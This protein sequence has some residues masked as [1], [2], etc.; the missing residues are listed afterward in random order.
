MVWLPS[1]IDAWCFYLVLLNFRLLELGSAKPLV[2]S[3]FSFLFLVWWIRAAI[4][5]PLF[6][7]LS[8]NNVSRSPPFRLFVWLVA[9]AWC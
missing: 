5:N 9:G 8:N 2:S 7:F 4:C 3:P 1:K 6:F